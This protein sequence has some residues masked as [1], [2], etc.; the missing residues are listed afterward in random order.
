[1]ILLSSCKRNDGGVVITADIKGLEVKWV[2]LQEIAAS[3]NEVIDS[4]EVRDGKFEFSFKP[5]TAFQPKFVSIITK[6]KKM[7]VLAFYNS[8]SSGDATKNT[9]TGLIM[10]PGVTELKG[11]LAKDHG[12]TIKAGPQNEVYFKNINLP[13][14]RLSR[15]TMIN[16]ARAI[17]FK[18][19]V[20]E[21]PDA[22]W[23]FYSFS[24]YRS[25][26]THRQLNE[27]YKE[28]SDNIKNSPEG[29]KT[30]LF[31]D[32]QPANKSQFVKGYYTDRSAN[33]FPLVDSTKKLNIIA[34]WAS[35]CMPCRQEIP[36]LMSIRSKFNKSELRIVS[37]SIDQTEPDWLQAVDQESMN[38]LQLRIKPTELDIATARYNLLG[39][40]QLYLVD[41]KSRVLEHFEGYEEGNE[42]KLK[43]LITNY[44][45]KN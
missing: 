19:L 34:F 35:W 29:K 40:P 23:L 39:I 5:D 26:F 1:M 18:K 42:E 16:N 44:L 25:K 4:A 38:W 3:G 10:E 11:D 8:Y 43:A 12:I 13:Y 41:G 6:N 37:V 17:S 22:F 20:T 9:Y 28:F 14:I 15:D 21:T 2:Y 7:P 45:S 27:V 31:L 30:K 32:N 36:G 33:S 24:N